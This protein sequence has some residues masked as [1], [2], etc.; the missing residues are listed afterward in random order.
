VSSVIR[1]IQIAVSTIQM[2]GNKPNAAPS[3]AASRACPAGIPKAK[4]ATPRATASDANP[5]C[6]AFQCSAP[7]STKRVSSGKAATSAERARDPPTGFAT[8]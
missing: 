6:Q 1:K 8:C 2:I 4:M 5:A 7:S 3:P